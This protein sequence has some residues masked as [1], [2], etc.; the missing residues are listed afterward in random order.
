MFVAIAATIVRLELAANI[1][2]YEEIAERYPDAW[3]AECVAYWERALAACLE[4]GA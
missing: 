3:T 4:I 1:L 2:A